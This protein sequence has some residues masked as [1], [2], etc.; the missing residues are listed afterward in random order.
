MAIDVEN[1]V[2]YIETVLCWHQS[3]LRIGIHPLLKALKGS[4]ISIEATYNDSVQ[5]HTQL[6]NTTTILIG[7]CFF[8]KR[9]GIYINEW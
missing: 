6:Y 2:V 3:I 7:R 4:V 1:L 8:K 9:C 5:E